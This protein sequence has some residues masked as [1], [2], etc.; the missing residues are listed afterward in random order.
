MGMQDTTAESSER[1]VNK[2]EPGSWAG[3]G[4]YPAGGSE[5]SFRGQLHL[6]R[7]QKNM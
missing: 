5:Q 7:T 4:L 2:V 1:G 3:K 6:G